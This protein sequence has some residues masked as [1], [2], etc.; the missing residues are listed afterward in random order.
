MKLFQECKRVEAQFRLQ[1]PLDC[2]QNLWARQM[3]LLR[4]LDLLKHQI[5][6]ALAL[7]FKVNKPTTTS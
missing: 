1:D 7:L 5:L 2:N 6:D 4:V 3:L